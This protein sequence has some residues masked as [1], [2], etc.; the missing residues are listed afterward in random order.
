MWGPPICGKTTICKYALMMAGLGNVNIINQE[1][2]AGLAAATSTAEGLL[3][4]CDDMPWND[5]V[6]R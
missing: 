5:K 4:V 6:R 1:T 3:V 2:E